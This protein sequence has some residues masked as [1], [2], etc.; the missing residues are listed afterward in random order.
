M[1]ISDLGV[2]LLGCISH[3]TTIHRPCCL[4]AGTRRF[5]RRVN[6]VQL[7]RLPQNVDER[8]MRVIA[9]AAA[10][11]AAV[12]GLI[13]ISNRQ[14]RLAVP[15]TGKYPPESLPEGAFDAVIVGGGPSG[16]TCAYYMA[17]GGAKVEHAPELRDLIAHDQWASARRLFCLDLHQYKQF[18]DTLIHRTAAFSHMRHM[19]LEAFGT[20]SLPQVVVLDKETFPRDKYCGDA[21]CTPAIRILDD[22]GVMKV[23]AEN[24]ESHFAD[25]GGF[26]SPSGLSYI[27]ERCRTTWSASHCQECWWTSCR[28]CCILQWHRRGHVS[29]DALSG[30]WL[31]AGWRSIATPCDRCIGGE[32]GRGS[33]VRGEAHKPGLP[34][35]S[36]RQACG[37]H[38]P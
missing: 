32:A 31:N 9:A 6:M 12:G 27:G 34:H 21:V 30:P 28:R 29:A 17:Q 15:K 36:G 10:G 3:S 5:V 13:Y 33:C 38:I 24:N 37:S 14:R 25:A 20:R 8:Q 18:E 2:E 16:S 7:P 4:R 35:R 23:L 11:A 1:K 26:V 22:M 19:R